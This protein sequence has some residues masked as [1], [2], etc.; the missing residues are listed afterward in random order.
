KQQFLFLLLT[1]LTLTTTAQKITVTTLSGS[2]V[3]VNIVSDSI[4]QK[5]LNDFDGVQDNTLRKQWTSRTFRL[6]DKR[7]LIEFYDKQA[8]VI[9]SKEDFEKL[10]EIRFAKNYIDFLRKNV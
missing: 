9:A 5:L 10:N 3:E 1:L 6:S 8:A 4:K 2:K 7:L